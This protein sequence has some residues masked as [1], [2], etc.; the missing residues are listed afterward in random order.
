[1]IVAVDF[2]GTLALGNYSHISLLEPNRAL[3]GRLQELKETANPMIKIVTARGGKAHLSEAQKRERYLALIE[4]WLLRYGVPYDEITFNKEYANLYIDD[5]T[6]LPFDD[7]RGMTSHFTKSK[8]I[9]TDR[10]VIKHSQTAL[11]EFEW[12]KQAR[13]VGLNVPDVLFCNDE[14]IITERIPCSWNTT[15]KN[16]IDLCR[17]F[18]GMKPFAY[19]SYQTYIENIEVIDK[20]SEKTRAAVR[21]IASLS[22]PPTF[23][24][25]DL[26]TT[27]VLATEGGV[28]LIDPNAKYIFGSY[29]TDAGKAAFSLIAYEQQFN[30]ARLIFEA[31]PD[32]IYFAI[33]EGLR[34]CKYRPE[35][36]SI[37][38]NIADVAME[39]KTGS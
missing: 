8:I 7:F 24:Q 6:I 11:F 13:A 21:C 1:M 29:L 36:I 35:Y 5:Q 38:N 19:N 3:I 10:T 20:A 4:A 34:V 33:A 15:A 16:L 27:N 17:Q 22:H 12:Y 28:Y 37:V 2:D 39:P 30:Q 18:K 9:F 14:C 32:S 26:S 23:F 31:F 25:G